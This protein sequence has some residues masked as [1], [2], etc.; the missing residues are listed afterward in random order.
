MGALEP[1]HL[2]IILI[3]VLV[4]FGP[5]KLPQL[6]KAIGDGIRE[7]KHATNEENAS[8]QGSSG[9]TSPTAASPTAETT[10][11]CP[12]CKA[13][14]PVSARFCGTCGRPLETAAIITSSNT[15]SSVL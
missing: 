3:L 9:S 1:P 14:M 10:R 13:V 4:I 5:G 2:I 6:G 11:S 15:P 7:L 12:H 8:T